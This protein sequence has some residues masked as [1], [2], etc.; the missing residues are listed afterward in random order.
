MLAKIDSYNNILNSKISMNVIIREGMSK[1][2]N[3]KI[4]MNL[5]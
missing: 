2:L 4:S 1:L 3:S 5:Q